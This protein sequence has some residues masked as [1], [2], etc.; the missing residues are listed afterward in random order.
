MNNHV[1]KDEQD[2]RGHSSDRRATVCETRS[3]D[4][5][6][7]YRSLSS[8]IISFPVWSVRTDD[9]GKA[10]K[11]CCRARHM[12]GQQ[13]KRQLHFVVFGLLCCQTQPTCGYRLL[14]LL[15]DSLTIKLISGCNTKSLVNVHQK[16]LDAYSQLLNPNSKLMQA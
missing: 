11:T 10:V 3:Q 7:P 14:E 15:E 6:S 13:M 12:H 5:A 1:A 9:I 16:T 4:M 8:T 2:L